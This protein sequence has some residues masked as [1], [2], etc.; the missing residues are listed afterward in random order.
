LEFINFVY[1]HKLT[2][3]DLVWYLSTLVPYGIG[4]ENLNFFT[5]SFCAT[6]NWKNN[7][8]AL[9]KYGFE[10]SG[11]NGLMKFKSQIHMPVWTWKI[12]AF[13]ALN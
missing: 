13:A 10:I 8:W 5:K 4:N 7:P 12:I 3:Y 2:Y 1:V 11:H 6:I 9:D